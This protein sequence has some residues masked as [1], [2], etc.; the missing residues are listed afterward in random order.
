MKVKIEIELGNEAMQTN[1]DVA[2][3][4]TAVAMRIDDMGGL[5]MEIGE[6]DGFT[7]KDRNGNAVGKLKVV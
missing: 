1:A 7:I 5:E 3:V 2:E 4:L 6:F